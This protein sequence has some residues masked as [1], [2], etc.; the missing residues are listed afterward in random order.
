MLRRFIALSLV[1]PWWLLL[2]EAVADTVQHPLYAGISGG[3]GWTTWQGLVPP[4]NRRN[5]AMTMSTPEFVN[6]GGGLWGLFLGYEF[7]PTFAL[8]AAYS[9]YPN[10]KVVFD[11]DS[12]FAFEHNQNQFITKTETVSLLAKIMMPIPKTAIR[13]YSGIGYAEVHRCDDLNDHWMGSPTFGVGV[14]YPIT[15]R[16]MGELG[17]NYTAGKGQSELNP[18]EDY[19]PFLYSVFLRVAYRVW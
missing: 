6:E 10:A 16:I 7:L 8:E 11:A 1:L 13:A 18:V 14:N 12:I 15:E 2:N 9:R 5:M 4:P 19:F 17:A 3:Y